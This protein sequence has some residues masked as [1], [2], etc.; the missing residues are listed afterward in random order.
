MGHPGGQEWP[1]DTEALLAD[2]TVTNDGTRPVLVVQRRPERMASQLDFPPDD[3]EESTWVMG[4]SDGEVRISKQMFQVTGSD[5]GT[6]YLVPA[7]LLGP[8]ESVSGRAVAA[9]PLRHL[10]PDPELFEVPED[11]ELPSDATTWQFCVQVAP[12]GPGVDP[13]RPEVRHYTEGLELLCS[14]RAQL[15]P[16]WQQQGG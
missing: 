13:D 12:E 14:D 15:P 10:G 16:D 7:A 6:A 4:T 3:S 11:Q 9:L 1:P 8:G 5:D 2:Y